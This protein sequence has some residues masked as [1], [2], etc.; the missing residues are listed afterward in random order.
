MAVAIFTVTKILHRQQGSLRG[1]VPSAAL[2]ARDQASIVQDPTSPD[3]KMIRASATLTL[4]LTSISAVLCLSR[5]LA[6]EG[7][8]FPGCPCVHPC[9]RDHIL[10]EHDYFTN[11][12][13]E[14]HQI[15][16]LGAF[17][18]KDKPIIF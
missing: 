5:R 15:Y 3:G 18:D 7:I 13:R 11:R 17:W 12:P 16:N 2:L 4:C 9:V 14:F 1:L 10:K 8:L 6:V